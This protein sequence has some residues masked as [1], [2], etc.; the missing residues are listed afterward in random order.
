MRAEAWS[1]VAAV[2]FGLGGIAAAWYG[3]KSFQASKEQQRSHA[4][5]PLKYLV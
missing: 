5:K 3:Y 2:V 1:L 4:N